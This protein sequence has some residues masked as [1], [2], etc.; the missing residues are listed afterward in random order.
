MGALAATA[1]VGGVGVRGWRADVLLR[2]QGVDV[3]RRP[4]VTDFCGGAPVFLSSLRP[5]SLKILEISIER[6]W[7]NLNSGGPQRS[8][9][10]L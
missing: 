9:M 7:T 4:R 2:S 10:R 6:V 3:L 5:L 8:Q 1:R